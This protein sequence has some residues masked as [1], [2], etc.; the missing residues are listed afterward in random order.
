VEAEK[1]RWKLE[2]EVNFKNEQCSAKVYPAKIPPS[3]SLAGVMGL[4]KAIIVETDL[5]GPIIIVGPGAGRFA[6]GFS[7]LA[8]I[9][10]IHREYNN[11]L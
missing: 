6:T 8:D 10:A 11:K 7:L 1:R 4:V 5:M 3:D 9:L 2:G